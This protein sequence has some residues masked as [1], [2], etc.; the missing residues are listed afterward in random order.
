MN[1]D[2]E[3]MRMIARFLV[4]R[5]DLAEE[6]EDSSWKIWDNNYMISNLIKKIHAL[7]TT[8]RCL[9]HLVK[10]NHWLLTWLRGTSIPMTWPYRT[11]S[12][13]QTEIREKGAE[14]QQ[15]WSFFIC[16]IVYQDEGIILIFRLQIEELFPTAPEVGVDFGLYSCEVLIHLYCLRSCFTLPKV[17]G[18]AGVE[19][20]ISMS[21]GLESHWSHCKGLK[22][23]V[24]WMCLQGPSGKWHYSLLV[25]CTS[26]NQ[27]VTSEN[28]IQRYAKNSNL[29]HYP[30][31]KYT[32][33]PPRNCTK[34]CEPKARQIHIVGHV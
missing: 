5:L 20:P 9:S 17:L 18:C 24:H 23:N 30:N 19:I 25:I 28:D 7:V 11:Q 22:F 6:I 15:L 4:C 3:A 26:K 8:M 27:W 34:A 10:P 2:L 13:P 12:Y 16:F 1:N 29:K 32:H 33:N 31:T 21:G 14:I